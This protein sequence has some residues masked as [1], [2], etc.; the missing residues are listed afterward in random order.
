VTGGH[1]RL[2]TRR[3]GRRPVVSVAGGVIVHAV[4]NCHE[5][6]R[7]AGVAWALAGTGAFEQLAVDA[8]AGSGAARALADLDVPAAVRRLDVAGASAAQRLGAL[9]E[10]MCG[11]VAATTVTAV[12][13][14]DDGDAG[15]A[16]A[17]AAARQ[18]LP[19]VYVAGSAR[20]RGRRARLLAH[21][22][23][24]VLVAE[25][26]DVAEL[27]GRG[28][29][30]ERLRAVGDPLAD[31]VRRAAARRAW[32]RRGVERR[33]YVFAAIDRSDRPE[34]AAELA[35]LAER[36][37]SVVALSPAVDGAW[38]G[39][40]PFAALKASPAR[41]VAWGSCVDR[42]ALAGAAGAVV[43]DCDRLREA[44]ALVGVPAHGAAEVRSVRPLPRRDVV[45]MRTGRAGPRVAE[46]VVTNFA[47]LR[48]EG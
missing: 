11:A 35:L 4:G 41:I 17:L 43:T 46:T 22:A 25:E 39:T 32:L 9:E 12:M 10:A 16:A 6:P 42:L 30:P 24:L 40:A 5:V 20:R 23:D 8:S 44:A 38:R 14:Y 45:P 3:G 26:D 19:L 36:W 33:R 31:A 15:L 48:L 2:V 47:R 29:A 13:V 1:L 21:M 34:L 37:R 28:V 18:K 7:M 27:V